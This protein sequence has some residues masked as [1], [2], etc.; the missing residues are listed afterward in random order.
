MADDH[1]G[2]SSKNAGDYESQSPVGL[3]RKRLINNMRGTMRL[4][5]KEYT[6][7]V[8]KAWNMYRRGETAKTLSYKPGGAHPEEYP[9]PI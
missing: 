3:L 7:L 6:A 1:S 4:G 9:T 5:Q 8:L 2:Y